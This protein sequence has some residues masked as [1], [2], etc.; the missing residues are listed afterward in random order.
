MTQVALEG[1]LPSVSP[2]VVEVFVHGEWCI[3][4]DSFFVT[5]L[6]SMLTLKKLKNSIVIAFSKEEI[7]SIV[8]WFWQRYILNQIFKL[9]VVKV[10]LNLIALKR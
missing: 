2:N 1:L 7:H 10:F 5:F 8:S 6:E 4:A 3:I 9:L